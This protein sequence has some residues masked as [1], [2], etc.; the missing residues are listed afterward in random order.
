LFCL[1]IKGENDKPSVE[2]LVGA[3][4]KAFAPEEVSAMV[5]NTSHIFLYITPYISCFQEQQFARIIYLTL[6]SFY[7]SLDSS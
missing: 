6:M 1:V 4:R 7:I 3:D 5:S 2:V